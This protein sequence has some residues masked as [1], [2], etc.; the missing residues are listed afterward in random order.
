MVE[1]NWTHQQRQAIITI[2]QLAF[3]RVHEQGL[4]DDEW[5]VTLWQQLARHYQTDSSTTGTCNPGT[6]LFHTKHTITHAI[7][8]KPVSKAIASLISPDDVR[9]QVLLDLLAIVLDLQ[10]DTL[11]HITVKKCRI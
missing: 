3:A 11:V 5:M 1:T 4:M 9:F 7:I 8:E 2:V 10:T 6:C